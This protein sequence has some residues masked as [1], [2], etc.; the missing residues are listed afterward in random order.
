MTM[1]KSLFQSLARGMDQDDVAYRKSVR[2]MSV[3]LA[4]IVVIIFAAIFIPPYL[5][6]YHDVFPTS[7]SYDSPFGFTMH[8]TLNSTLVSPDGRVSITGWV[9]SSSSSIENVTAA[10][11]WAFQQNLLWGE[12]CTAGWPIGVGVMKGHY[13]Q[14][15]YTL[16]TPLPL[17]QPLAACPGTG[18]PQYFLFYPHSSLALASIN[19]TPTRW[20]IQVGLSFS[21]RSLRPATLPGGQGSNQLPPGVYTAVL[22]DEWGD[23]LTDSFLVT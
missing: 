9:N 17:N 15:N 20:V 4:V 22:A 18:P 5:S 8:L 10:N 13:T 3:I 23:V 7:A 2:N 6:P 12:I 14:D 19:G 16:G 1:V 11:Q 21:D